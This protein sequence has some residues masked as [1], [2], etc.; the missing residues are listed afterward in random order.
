M[1][2]Y[3]EAKN[4]NYNYWK[5]KPVMR[6]NNKVYTSAQIE[7]TDR[8]NKY[9]PNEHIELPAGLTWDKIDIN[10][11]EK[12][13]HLST[14]LTN[15]YD[16][17]DDVSYTISYTPDMI[18]WEMNHSGYFMTILNRDKNIVGTI[19]ITIKNVQINSDKIHMMEPIYLCCD[20]KLRKKG[21]ACVLLDE[22]IRQSILLKIDK[23]IYCDNR[24]VPSPIAT[25]R[26]YARPINYKKLRENDFV[27]I[28]GVDD[29]VVHD[30]IRISIAPNKKYIIAEKNEKNI[31][32][33]YDLYCRYMK[34]FNIHLIMTTEDIANYFFDERFVR[35]VLVTNDKNDVVDFATYNFYDI[36]N[37]KKTDNNIIRAANILMYTSNEVRVDLIFINILKQISA[38]KINIVYINDMM[39]SNEI[40]LS[41]IKNADDDTDD[42][43]ENTSY[44]LNIIKTGKK[45]FLNLFNWK[46][47]KLK[48]MMVSW[49]IF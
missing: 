44:D 4:H 6:L 49:L 27:E 8:M 18:R 43:E 41:K 10:D 36:I 24:L 3:K 42:E 37:T 22:G 38:D 23:G 15:N 25:I 1:K 30:K 20:R 26:Q 39:H 33:V 40:I 12:M 45:Y 48:Q 28:Y 11:Q 47:E 16:R 34:T 35:T 29:D 13:N 31:K 5:N 32:K 9:C 21:M 46:C 14:F 2:S 17:G 19:G 7:P